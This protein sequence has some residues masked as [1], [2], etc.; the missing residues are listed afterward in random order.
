MCCVEPESGL[1]TAKEGTVSFMA[2]ADLKKVIDTP[3]A[4]DPICVLDCE[5]DADS[6]KAEATYKA[7]RIPGAYY[8]D[9]SKFVDVT[10]KNY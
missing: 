6:A 5:I 1:T 2:P 9:L 7:H 8:L 10:S 4:T 3:S